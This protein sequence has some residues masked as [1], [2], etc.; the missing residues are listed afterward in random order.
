[1]LCRIVNSIAKLDGIKDTFDQVD[2]FNSLAWKSTFVF[3]KIKG[4]T[5]HFKKVATFY[6]LEDVITNFIFVL[7]ILLRNVKI[8]TDLKYEKF[9]CLF[10]YFLQLQLYTI[11]IC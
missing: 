11:S 9:V 7:D 1:M 2:I 5:K 10:T 4:F 3:S 8:K 6:C